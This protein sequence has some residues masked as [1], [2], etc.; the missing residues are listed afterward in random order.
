MKVLKENMC[1][2]VD[3]EIQRGSFAYVNIPV[4][5]LEDSS[6]LIELLDPIDDE[7]MCEIKK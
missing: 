1:I 5:L 6:S 3:V 4:N 2:L 7:T